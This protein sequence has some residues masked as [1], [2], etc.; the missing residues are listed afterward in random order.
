MGCIYRGC[1][2]YTFAPLQRVCIIK[3]L[4]AIKITSKR[5]N[6]LVLGKKPKT[7]L[8]NNGLCRN[9]KVSQKR[10]PLSINGTAGIVNEIIR[11]D[12]IVFSQNKRKGSFDNFEIIKTR[13]QQKL[14]FFKSIF[15]RNLNMCYLQYEVAFG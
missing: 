2:S 8:K 4:C 3:T 15:H 5:H 14:D 1:S 13:V 10:F 9:R 6:S 12:W 11:T 7:K